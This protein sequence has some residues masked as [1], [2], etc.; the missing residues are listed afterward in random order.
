MS[1]RWDRILFLSCPL[2]GYIGT[3]SILDGPWVPFIAGIVGGV[4]VGLLLC[5]L[6]LRELH[7]SEQRQGEDGSVYG[8]GRRHMNALSAV[9]VLVILVNDIELTYI[10]PVLPP[11]VAV[12]AEVAFL[13]TPLAVLILST[14]LTV[15]HRFYPLMSWALL[16]AVSS[17]WS[18]RPGFAAARGLQSLGIVALGI[19]TWRACNRQPALGEGVLTRVGGLLAV[20]ILLLAG[21]GAEST[22]DRLSFGGLHPV[23]AGLLGVIAVLLLTT[24]QYRHRRN[25]A[26]AGA[27][28]LLVL[29]I[30]L[31][32]ETRTA[33]LSMGT[34]VIAYLL[35]RRHRSLSA[36]E[37]GLRAVARLSIVVIV[38][39]LTYFG[40]QQVHEVRVKSAATLGTLNERVP[41]WQFGVEQVKGLQI[42]VGHGWGGTSLVYERTFSYAA[43]N[44]HST[45]VEAYIN[46]GLIGLAL[47]VSSLVGLLVLSARLRL[48][49]HWAVGAALLTMSITTEV[50]ADINFGFEIMVLLVATIAVRLPRSRQ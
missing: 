16:L 43:G 24:S 11:A 10:L 23:R 14:R 4:V 41:A 49:R 33:V 38:L 19:L 46:L 18:P 6:L 21:T 29:A 40:V 5:R 12:A 8:P 22:G 13:S 44:A 34:A 20:G 27:L 17:A 28:A 32:S 31:R 42:V 35:F 9:W 39:S 1:G 45:W 7:G 37:G 47:L 26:L 36:S 30:A 25:R 50:V 15:P 48:A 2:A 3:T